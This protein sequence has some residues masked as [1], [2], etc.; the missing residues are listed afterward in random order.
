VTGPAEQEPAE[1]EPATELRSSLAT[2]PGRLAVALIAVGAVAAT[3]IGVIA[4]Q[5]GPADPPDP[6]SPP[7]PSGHGP[8]DLPLAAAEDGGELRIVESGFTPITDVAGEPMVTWGLVVENT[9]RETAASVTVN[10][11]ILDQHGDSLVTEISDYATTREISLVMPGQRAGIGD[12]TYVT[13]PDVAEMSFRLDNP[14][15]LPVANTVFPVAALTAGD[16][17]T[18]REDGRRVLMYWD[19]EGIRPVEAEHGPLVVQFRVESGYDRILD[20]PSAQAVFRDRDGT[21]VGGTHPGDTD[22]WTTIPPGWSI[23]RI[24]TGDGPPA[25]ADLART[26]VYVYPT[27]C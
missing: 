26:E 23:Q 21:I 10:L 2:R 16:I 5:R 3:T 24:R 15:W 20:D 27:C 19:E 11:D 6:A 9:S 4:A 12:A 1:S 25:S 8:A 17:E 22:L 18:S 13:A 14:R 7:T